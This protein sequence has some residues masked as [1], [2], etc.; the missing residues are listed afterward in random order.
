MEST[1]KLLTQEEL[2]FLLAPPD[3]EE[4]G[5]ADAD[6]K[7]GK[8]EDFDA[9]PED[10]SAEWEEDDAEDGAD[11]ET[12]PG[13]AGLS[14][15]AASGRGRRES[16]HISDRRARKAA[17]PDDGTAIRARAFASLF[18]RELARLTGAYVCIE[19][20]SDTVCLCRELLAE[21]D[22][23]AALALLGAA[24]LASRLLFYCDPGLAQALAD[25][26]LG[27]GVL[28]ESRRT[29][30]TLDLI[31]VR[32]LLAVLPDCLA[33]AWD[34]PRAV[35]RRQVERAAD[36]FLT[37]PRD[38]VRVLGFTMEIESVRG[39]CLLAWS[40]EPADRGERSGRF[41]R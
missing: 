37:E 12:D 4:A 16:V 26:S 8:R 29:L 38:R 2:D 22:E 32:R 40:D 27:A 1:R 41:S 11:G 24:P 30:T 35:F 9:V 10:D 34:L 20:R 6:K 39:R 33:D 14:A 17:L 28:P 19:H 31:L 36:I 21:L 15:P 7:D 5:S 3:G 25:V 13:G 23:P 18:E